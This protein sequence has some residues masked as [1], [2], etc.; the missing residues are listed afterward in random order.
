MLA[1]VVCLVPSYS[2]ESIGKIETVFEQLKTMSKKTNP[3]INQHRNEVFVFSSA[4]EHDEEKFSRSQKKTRREFGLNGM[5][6]KCG[7]DFDVFGNCMG[8]REIKFGLT[9]CQE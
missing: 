8:N 2:R 3:K 1:P 7:E 9:A 6:M 5:E 4:R